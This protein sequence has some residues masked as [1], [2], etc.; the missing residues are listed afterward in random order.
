MLVGVERGGLVVLGVGVDPG[1]DLEGFLLLQRGKDQ[2]KEH[3][4]AD[5]NGRK[6]DLK[7]NLSFEV[8]VLRWQFIFHLAKHSL[9]VPSRV[10]ESL[11]LQRFDVLPEKAFAFVI[12]RGLEWRDFGL[13]FHLW[14]H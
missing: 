11:D 2:R 13:G 6:Q 5:E 9:L 12:L 1:V 4:E 8:Y 3:G 7:I 10:M 14:S